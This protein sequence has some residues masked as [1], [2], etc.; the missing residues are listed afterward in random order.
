MS[1]NEGELSFA[2]NE[3]S[4]HSE[5]VVKEFVLVFERY[6]GDKTDIQHAFQAFLDWK[7]T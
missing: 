7:K 6:L 4:S 5:V 1:E 2:L 3:V